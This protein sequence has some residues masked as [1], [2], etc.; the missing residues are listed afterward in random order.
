MPAKS[1]KQAK[2]MRAAAHGWKPKGKD[3]PSEGV[4]RK[5]MNTEGSMGVQRLGRVERA[6]AKK[7]WTTPERI[8]TKQGP[9]KKGGESGWR[10]THSEPNP[11]YRKN[12]RSHRTSAFRRAAKEEEGDLRQKYGPVKEIRQ[13]APTAAERSEIIRRAATK[14]AEAES[15]VATPQRAKAA[16]GAAKGETKRQKAATTAAT[17]KAE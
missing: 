11:A 12:V 10:E 17:E 16:L 7:V 15:A 14:K 9:A 4:A 13:A 8:T 5:F 6:K 3:V 2:F 1:E